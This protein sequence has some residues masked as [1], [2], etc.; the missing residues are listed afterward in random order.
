[1]DFTFSD[2]PSASSQA[3]IWKNTAPGK[4]PR[5]RPTWPGGSQSPARG[6]GAAE[7]SRERGRPLG[8]AAGRGG[9]E[10]SAS[11]VGLGGLA[12]AGRGRGAPGLGA[13]PA[14]PGRRADGVSKVTL[15]TATFSGGGGNTYDPVDD[16]HLRAPGERPP[17][18][19]R[20]RRCVGCEREANLGARRALWPNLGGF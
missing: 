20:F 5:L 2:K 6:C 18:A 9:P 10:R 4:R 11:A 15:R 7:V 17:R 12:W 3:R 19:R 1:M 8:Y 13:R 14:A 16:L